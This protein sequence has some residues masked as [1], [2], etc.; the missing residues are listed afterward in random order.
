MMISP[1]QQSSF[2]KCKA[3]PTSAEAT[4]LDSDNKVKLVLSI[5]MLK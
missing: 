2:M 4:A 1:N 5:R 3:P